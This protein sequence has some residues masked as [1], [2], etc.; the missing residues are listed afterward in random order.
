MDEIDKMQ[1]IPDLER[2]LVLT[3]V[4]AVDLPEPKRGVLLELYVQAVLFCR[5]HHFRKEQTSAL[6]SI[7]KSI[8]EAN[9]GTPLD[10]I[11]ACFR[12]CRELLLCHSVRRPPF[13]I[14]LFSFE[15][16]NWV[17]KYIHSSYMRH[18]KLYRYVFTPQVRKKCKLDPLHFFLQEGGRREE[19]GAALSEVRNHPP[20]VWNC[21]M[22]SI[23]GSPSEL[24]ALIEQEVRQQM[25]LVSGQLDQR[26]KE[27]AFQH[28]N[29]SDSSQSNH[30]TKK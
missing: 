28:N 7:L 17:L 5:E 26:M 27:M 4:F 21:L 24:K 22:F 25:A 3:S 14:N 23:S 19:G 11:E 6:L 10:N 1:S 12:H 29:T 18:Y 16:V 2:F 9:V 30:K 13:S 8:H 15:E 20:A